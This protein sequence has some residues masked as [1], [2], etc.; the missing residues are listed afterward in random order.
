MKLDVSEIQPGDVLLVTGYSGDDDVFAGGVASSLA[1]MGAKML[2]FGD[3]DF[4]ISLLR[5]VPGP[6]RFDEI[7]VTTAADREPRATTSS[8]AYYAKQYE[9]ALAAEHAL[10]DDALARP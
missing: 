8:S 10:A 5:G 7:D 2:M 4:D 9:A 1:S 6:L 3:G